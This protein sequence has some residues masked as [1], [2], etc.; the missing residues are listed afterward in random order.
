MREIPAETALMLCCATATAATAADVLASKSVSRVLVTLLSPEEFSWELKLR[1]DRTPLGAWTMK[2][3]TTV[4]LLLAIPLP[5]AP[6]PNS[7]VA[8]CRGN[9]GGE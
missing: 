3:P 9:M 6:S 5:S 2:P 7:W 4:V 1:G 8:A